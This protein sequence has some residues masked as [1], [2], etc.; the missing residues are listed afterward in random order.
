MHAGSEIAVLEMMAMVEDLIA[1][2]SH[3]FRAE[4]RGSQG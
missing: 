4:K 3:K 2:F 1:S